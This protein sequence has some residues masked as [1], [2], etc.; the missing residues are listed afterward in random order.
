RKAPVA[1]EL[2]E[3]VERDAAWWSDDPDELAHRAL[4][5]FRVRLMQMR[6]RL[7]RDEAYRA[8]NLLADLELL[9]RALHH[10][11]LADVAEEGA[12]AEAMVRARVFGLHMAT[13][14]IRQHS[15]VHEQA[16]AELLHAGGVTGDYL[17]MSEPQR[18]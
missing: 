15:G 7:Q 10:A 12:L 2:R 9:R 5:P 18:L 1:P 8:A 4:E 13:L 3:A 17:A 16:V 14:D 6:A 11:G